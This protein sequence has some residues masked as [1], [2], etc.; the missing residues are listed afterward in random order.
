MKF[1]KHIFPAIILITILLLIW[2]FAVSFWK[3]NPH[4]LPSPSAIY[5]AFAEHY[6]ILLP[7]IGQTVLETIIGLVLAVILGVSLAII[8]SISSLIRKAL[9]P[10]LVISQTIPLIAL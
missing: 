8:L 7:H 5:S 2:E 4:I 6:N 3:I 1:F 10:L 9:Y